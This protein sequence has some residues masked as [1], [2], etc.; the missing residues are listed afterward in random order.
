MQPTRRQ[1]LTNA[2]I[3]GLGGF[4]IGFCGC[5]TAPMTGRRQL[6]LIPESQEISLG[7]TAFE[8]TVTSENLSTNARLSQMVDRVGQRIAKV[9]NRS[10]YNWEFRLIADQTQN[11]F[12][13]PGGKVA[14]YEGILPICHDEAG[15]AVVMSHEVAHAL[16]RHGGER[17]SQSMAADK[18]KAVAETL[19]GKY[20]PDKQQL[21]MQAYGLGTKYGVLLPYS[22]KQESEADHIGIKLMAKAGYDPVVA[23][24][25]WNRFASIKGDGQQAEFLS[26]HP[27]DQRRS[28]DLLALM[29]EAKSIYQAS[30]TKFGRGESLVS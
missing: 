26:T 2:G 24:D 13:L 23:P 17:M 10:D 5:K 9:S 1:I 14:I 12:C 20:V 21:L 29:D 19:A 4:G 18:V 25:F 28:A 16:A 27:S 7:V 3:L 30:S 15:L 22:R 11:A 6:I 8:E